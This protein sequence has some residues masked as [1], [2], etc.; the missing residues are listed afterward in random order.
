MKKR[1][2]EKRREEYLAQMKYGGF[3]KIHSV[4]SL[5]RFASTPLHGLHLPVHFRGKRVISSFP[6]V[7]NMYPLH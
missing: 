2:K 7:T 1:G 3:Y 6:N 5:S 4:N